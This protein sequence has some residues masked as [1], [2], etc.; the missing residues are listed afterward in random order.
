MKILGI[1]VDGVEHSVVFSFHREKANSNWNSSENFKKRGYLRHPTDKGK[2]YS[3]SIYDYNIDTY[4]IK[5]D[6]YYD[7]EM[8]ARDFLL[9]RKY[10]Q[11]NMYDSYTNLTD[12][13]KFNL[14]QARLF[15]SKVTNKQRCKTDHN[16]NNRKVLRNRSLSKFLF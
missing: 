10:I 16:P 6:I 1:F 5:S 3:I 13:T 11:H 8:L 4:Q 9:A 2:W 14:T 7:E 12:G 15:I